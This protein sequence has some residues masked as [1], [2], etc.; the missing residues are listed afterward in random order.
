MHAGVLLLAGLLLFPG[1]AAPS[2]DALSLFTLMNEAKTHVGF[3]NRVEERPEFNSLDYLYFYDGGGVAIGDVNNDGKADLFF[4]GNQVSNKLYLNRGDFAFDD[5]TERA[6]VG[7]DPE[8]WSTGVSMADVNGD[9]WLD[10]YVCQVNHKGK[11]GRNL[12]Y[13]NQGD[14]TFSEQAER[15]GLDFEGLSTQAAFFDYDRDGDLDLYLLNHAV[16]TR[17]AFRRAW[18]RIID[19]PRVGDK[20]YRNDGDRFVDVTRDAGIYSS[21]LGYGLGVA[22]SDMNHDGWPDIYVGNDFHENDYLYFNNGDGTFTEDLYRVIGH[23]SRSSMGNDVADFNNDGRVDILSLDMMPEDLATYRQSGG[24][25]AEELARIKRDF[26]YGPQHARNTLQLNR[27]DDRDGYPLFS[28]IG[29]YAGVH[30]TDWSWA[31]LFADLDN[32]G[33]KDIFITNGIFRRPNDLDYVEYISRPDVQRMLTEAPIEQQLQ[34]IE[35]MPSVG[36]PNYAFQ[37]QG[38]LTF[39]NVATAWGLGQPSFASGAAYGDLDNDGDLDLVTNNVNMPSSVYRNNS[40][41]LHPERHA[42]SVRL[43]G[44]GKNTAGIGAKVL[45]EAGTDRFYQEQSPTRGFQS[46]V[47]H[48]LHVG[49]GDHERIDSLLVIWPDGRFQHFQDVPVNQPLVLDQRDAH[50]HYAYD[51]KQT[52]DPLFEAVSAQAGIGV[53]HQENAYA[54]FETQP[55]IPHKLSTRGPAL[56]VADANGDGLDDVYVGGAHG[57]AGRLYMQRAEGGFDPSAGAAFVA[58]RAHED[59]DAAFVDVD[60]DGDQDLYVVSGGGEG[61]QDEQRFQDRLYLND[62][63]GQFE[64]APGHLPAFTADGASVAPADYDADGDIDL[65]VGSRSVPGHYGRSPASYLLENDGTGMF[66]DVTGQVA[67]TLQ[68]LGMVTDAQW[69]DVDGDARLDLVVV[70][71]WLPVTLMKNTGGQLV[72]ATEAMGMDALSGWWNTVATDDVDRDGDTDIVAG[73]LGANSM[74]DA[75]TAAPL[76]LFVDDFDGNGATDPI[77]TERRDGRYYTWARS[78]ELIAQLPGLRDALPNH[79]SYATATAEDLFGAARLRGATM[80]TAT[81]LESVYIENRGPE[82]FR[83]HRL[84]REVQFAPAHSV[85]VRDVDGDGHKDLLVAGNFLGVDTKQGRYD[86]G[87]GSLL[88]GDGQGNWEPAAPAASGFLVRGEA[89]A[90]EALR[91][92]DGRLLVIVART[93]RPPQL[94][95]RR[96][97]TSDRGDGF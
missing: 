20:L 10:I 62:S 34:V 69:A 38:D 28:E 89:R 84:P 82:G 83:A 61:V 73:N 97:G 47:A 26:G 17:D 74:F 19:A 49:L 75:S 30:A 22:I 81:M 11:R 33:W 65:F 29:R 86:A 58:D 6:G 52:A 92:A 39:S 2:S 23:T 35:R 4:T 43:V 12:L 42:L 80:K 68:Q 60:G 18:R 54:D 36:I 66:A 78:D 44:E 51:P 72:E 13:I 16:H 88:R 70:G 71:E 15:Y 45:I 24:E 37:N 7:G 25:D 1:C 27:G 32:D 59:V 31:G 63:R 53:A 3:F 64:R 55:L 48:T 96:A 57:Q 91:A 41:A 93:D 90:M 9:G 40:D 94:F 95:R 46:S 79:A 76:T 56:A 85:L 14:S 5:V 21:V 50:G 77:I 87:Y 8:E 67:P